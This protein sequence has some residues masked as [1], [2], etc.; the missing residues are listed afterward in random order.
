MTLCACLRSLGFA[1]LNRGNPICCP[2]IQ[3]VGANKI[4]RLCKRCLNQPRC[5]SPYKMIWSY[6]PSS[7]IGNQNICMVDSA[8]K[9][10]SKYIV[11]LNK[12][13]TVWLDEAGYICK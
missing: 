11:V 9:Y 2:F 13:P 3:V 5:D 6:L 7:M 10:I 12:D 8:K 1:R 4:K